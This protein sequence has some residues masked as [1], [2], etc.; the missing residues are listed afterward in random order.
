MKNY[1][2]TLI[3]GG[4]PSGLSLAYHLQGDTLIL[5]KEDRVGGLCR[6]F[7]VNGGVFDLGGH[8][9]HTPF[10]EVKKLVNTLMDGRMDE[11]P[12][13][14]RIF[15]HG[16]LIPYPFQKY[17]DQ[18]PDQQVVKDCYEGLLTTDPEFKPNNFEEFII[19]KFGSGIANHFMLPYNK[20]L[21]G[22]D[23]TRISNQWTSERV[24]GHKSESQVLTSEYGKRTPLQSDST[25]SYPQK[26]GFEEIFKEMA[27]YC[28]EIK[29]NQVVTKID[30]KNKIVETSHGDQYSWERLVSTIP[31]PELVRMIT[32]IP[33]DLVNL[34]QQLES[35]PL[36][37]EFFLADQRIQ[38]APQRVYSAAPEIP[39]HKIAFNH[40]SSK[41]LRTMLNHAIMAEVSFARGKCI[42]EL[43]LSS[44]CANAI[45]EIGQIRSIGE[46]IWQAH[47]DV[48]NGYPVPTH[49]SG[50]IVQQIKEY[51]SQFNIY[52]LGRFGEWEYI[53]SDN[54]IWRGK[55]LAETLQKT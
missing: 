55:K 40:T 1:R 20:K 11:F 37:I 47:F 35:I 14:A 30:P 24:A 34:A 26:G 10:P 12:R 50:K 5:E 27:K 29:S 41:Y 16:T 15:T 13:D 28:K 39:F 18:I 38:D 32:D 23:L 54:C 51:L 8:S 45:V 46:I 36:R 31:L 7:T 9:F 33:G 2:S 53:N 48:K 52:T 44:R 19:G 22:Q 4:G 3:I 25:V 6:S 43:D 49:E 17:Y 42:N 21:W